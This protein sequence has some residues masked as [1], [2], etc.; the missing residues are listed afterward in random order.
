M[1]V[2]DKI[3]GKRNDRVADARQRETI[4]NELQRTKEQARNSFLRALMADKDTVGTA[5]LKFFA[6]KKFRMIIAH[7][8]ITAMQYAESRETFDHILSKV[9]TMLN[10]VLRPH[11]T[12]LVTTLWKN[13]VVC[14]LNGNSLE[15]VPCDEILAN[16]HKELT[17]I[18]LIYPG[19]KVVFGVGRTLDE[20]CSL[21]QRRSMILRQPVKSLK[22]YCLC[23]LF[24]EKLRFRVPQ[25]MA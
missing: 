21:R 13:E 11:C 18:Q 3:V 15:K 7:V 2:L 10:E 22:N 20:D 12:E 24:S 4:Q 25:R 19:A 5:E 9:Q 17:N 14:L 6:G 16:V 8:Y 1:A 23:F